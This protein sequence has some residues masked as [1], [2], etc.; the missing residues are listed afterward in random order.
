M[1]AVM[2]PIIWRKIGLINAEMEKENETSND[3]HISSSKSLRATSVL[4]L[5]MTLYIFLV[6]FPFLTNLAAV[7]LPH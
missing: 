5:Q 4:E 6:H 2:F 7:E 3:A 1:L